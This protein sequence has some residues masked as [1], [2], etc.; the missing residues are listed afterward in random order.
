VRFT[1]PLILLLGCARVAPVPRVEELRGPRLSRGVPRPDFV[2]ARTNGSAF[3]FRPETRGTLTFLFF[4]YTNCPDVCP[5]HMQNLAHV[6]HGLPAETTRRVRVVFV[7]TDP[8]RDT[9][10]KLQRWVAKFDSSWVGLTGSPAAIAA[11]QTAAGMPEAIRE[12]ELPNGGG[13]GMTHGAQLWAFTPDDSAHVVYPWGIQQ[14]DLAADI[15]KLLLI[16]PGAL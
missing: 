16:W 1:L 6:L 15:P 3:D 11:A 5:L 13:Y 8:E 10:D 9:P 14:A 2:L 12:G 7:T 4:G